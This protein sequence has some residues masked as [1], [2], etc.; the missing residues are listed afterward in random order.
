MTIEDLEEWLETAID[1]SFDLG[2]TS[3]DAAKLIVSRMQAEGLV[4]V[5]T[6]PVAVERSGAHLHRDNSRFK[7]FHDNGKPVLPENC[8]GMPSTVPLLKLIR[9]PVAITEDQ[10]KSLHHAL[11]ASA[12]SFEPPV[13]LASPNDGGE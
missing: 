5:K 10:S 12:E 8:E 2:W 13:I 1:D 3:L 11:L 7:F 6:E 4:L 9:E